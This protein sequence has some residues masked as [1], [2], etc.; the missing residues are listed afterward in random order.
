ML[1]A[2][3][4]TEPITRPQSRIRGTARLPA[5]A[6][7]LVTLLGSVLPSFGQTF[8]SQFTGMNGPTFVALDTRAGTTWLYV[9]EHGSVPNPPSPTPPPNG[10]RILRFNL[11]T[12]STTPQVVANR[13]T[14]NGQ[15]ISPDGIVV[16]PATGDIFVADR[17][18]N[19]V[20]RL[21]VNQTSGA[22]TF[23]MG[24][25]SSTAG[26]ADEMHGPVGLARDAAGAIYVAEHG[27]TNGGNVNPN[28][29]A[30]YTVS[31]TT[32][33]R[34]WRLGNGF[35]VPY[36]VTVSGSSLFI[37]DGFNERIQ[38][39]DLNGNSTGAV[40]LPG[41]IPL[42]LS[43]EATGI[44]VAESSGNGGG[45]TQRVE[46]RSLTG[47]ATGVS[48][49]TSGSGSGQFSLPFHAVLDSSTNRLYVADYGN[50]RVQVF[51]IGAATPTDTTAPTVAGFSAGA[52]S[53]TS[54]PFTVT[55]SEAVTGV[56]ATAFTATGGGSSVT[57]VTGSGTT[58]TVNVNF[59]GTSGTVTLALNGTA[60][61]SIRDAANNFYAGGGTTSATFTITPPV[62]A[63]GPSPTL[64]G[65]V[66][67]TATATNQNATFVV[68]FSE[69]VTGVDASDFAITRTGT[70][71]GS[72]TGVT[73]SGTT[74]RVA[75]FY[76]GTLG[77]TGTIQMGIRTSGTGITGASGNAFLGNGVTASAAIPV[78]NA[79]VVE[80]I[81]PTVT[82]FTVGAASGSSVNFTVTFSETVTG[83]DASDFFV[84][85]TGTATGTVGAVTGSGT[86][87]TVPVAFSG[88]G[89]IQLT[90]V[91]GAS[92]NI[93][94]AATNW[95]AGGGSSGSTV[96]TLPTVGNPPVVTNQTVTGVMG[97]AI[98]P[99]TVTATNSP[100]SFSAPGLQAYGLAINAS[101][102]I[103]GTPTA[104][105]SGVSIPVTATKLA[106]DLIRGHF[107]PAHQQHV[108]AAVNGPDGA[109]A[110]E[111]KPFAQKTDDR[112]DID[113]AAPPL[114]LPEEPR[115]GQRRRCRGDVQEDHRTRADHEGAG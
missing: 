111:H 13:G 36:G 55:F 5:F 66:L 95:F 109:H 15:F 17:F 74:Y 52:A 80:G 8:V 82:S 24:W 100:T 67:D 101:G 98:T 32:A 62:A 53:G 105:A 47:A 43:T 38:I 102:V 30:K 81:L 96:F 112:T 14:S 83:V 33:T 18:R 54:V 31:G 65:W 68:T 107:E 108:L 110:A 49:G 92:A 60:N 34:V 94:D 3:G 77:F 69:A 115:A 28:V 48:F 1:S 85:P 41:I 89:T 57:S 70:T 37:S 99:V 58:Y 113:G 104:L 97:T 44:W 4:E 12:G 20:E 23:V 79:P 26:A 7:L 11:T 61:T 25:G 106:S 42:G 103:S 39:W 16:D 50:N 56:A 93:R 29:V 35:N 22:G 88:S 9:S 64:T 63:A 6:V 40:S 21:S 84:T 2:P 75:F 86:T 59:T 78:N 72:V 91:G 46:K 90:V 87:Y 27:D 73:G 19:R 71:N 51:T 76:D 114:D 45:A 10:G